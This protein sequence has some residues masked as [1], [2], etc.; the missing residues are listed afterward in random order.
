LRQAA[1]K[2][3]IGVIQFVHEPV[4]ALHG[5][6]R[7]QPDYRRV[8]DRL[9]GRSVLV[10]DWGGGTLDVTLCRIQ[11]GSI[12][13][14]GSQGDN[15]VGGDEFD[16]RLRNLLREKHAA[17]HKLED[18]T[19]LEQPGMATELLNQ[20]ELVKIELSRSDADSQDIIVRN[21]LRVEGPAQNL[22]ASV[23]KEE[24]EGVSSTI[25]ARGLGRIDEILEQTRLTNQDIELCLATGGMVNMPAIRNGLTERFIGRVP[26]LNNSD[27]IIAEGAAW[28]AN[29]DLRL[30]LA[31]PIEL[32]VADT[33]GSGTYYPLVPVGL[34]LPVE[35]KVMPA[36][37]SRL[38]CVDPREGI[39]VVE[40]AKP[41][42]TGPALPTD[43]R[44][45]LCVLNVPVDCRAA[46][47]LEK[48]SNAASKS[49]MTMWLRPPCAGQVGAPKPRLSF[50]T[51]ISA[52]PCRRM[53]NQEGDEERTVTSLMGEAQSYTHP[54]HDQTSR[55]ASM[56]RSR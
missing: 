41:V 26:K 5:Y 37:N 33:S 11:G 21:F 35:N 14:I 6:L 38:F 7:A 27:R 44:K 4:A 8:L 16:G 54:R 3:G 28:I 39:A 34:E 29:D 17:A 51:W 40:L 19:G 30:I 23:S 56:L 47:L 25:V 20:C 12:M 22:V 10:F 49:T 18:I 43:P 24:L 52:S 45:T 1:L 13:Q 9:E 36:A 2:A 46:P 53:A 42:R 31:K 32:L 55:N 15:E 50:M 48:G